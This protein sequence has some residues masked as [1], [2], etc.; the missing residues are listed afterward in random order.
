[1]NISLNEEVSLR[2]NSLRDQKVQASL[3]RFCRRH[4]SKIAGGT[5]STM[6][7]VPSTDQLNHDRSLPIESAHQNLLVR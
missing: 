4:F 5:F 1:V 3:S 6:A 7:K 2:H